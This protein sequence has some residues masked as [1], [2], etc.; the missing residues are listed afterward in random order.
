[1]RMYVLRLFSKSELRDP[2][3]QFL[4]KLG[5]RVARGRDLLG[6]RRLLLGDG[7]HVR[8]LLLHS[9]RDA[10]DLFY[11]LDRA[12]AVLF[13]GSRNLRELFNLLGQGFNRTGDTRELLVGSTNLAD[14]SLDFV[15]LRFRECK[16]TLDLRGILADDRVDLLRRLLALLGELSH[17]IGDDGESLAL[18]ARTCCLDGS[19]LGEE[20]RLA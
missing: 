4:R 16:C 19:I 1:M 6:G 11:R 12:L 10:A 7:G 9:V 5:K 17:L 2:R 14:I 20:L 18:L 8:R 3:L 15:L 13:E